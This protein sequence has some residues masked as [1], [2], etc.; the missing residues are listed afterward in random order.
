MDRFAEALLKAA[1]LSPNSKVRP[2]E[3]VMVVIPCALA[4]SYSLFFFF[5]LISAL[6]LARAIGQAAPKLLYLPTKTLVT[7]A[8]L[9]GGLC[10]ACL[11]ALGFAVRA[12][13][14]FLTLGS[15]MLNCFI[16]LANR[17][18]VRLKLKIRELA[19]GLAASLGIITP[20]E[21][22]GSFLAKVAKR[23]RRRVWPFYTDEFGQSYFR[24]TTVGRTLAL[25][26]TCVLGFTSLLREV[27]G[28][29]FFLFFTMLVFLLPIDIFSRANV[30]YSS[31]AAYVAVRV[32]IKIKPKALRLARRF[33]RFKAR[34][35]RYPSMVWFRRYVENKVAEIRRERLR[36]ALRVVFLHPLYF[37]W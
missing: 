25:L 24:R 28:A 17:H 5:A 31:L 8:P 22:E 30:F 20:Q 33:R 21:A 3:V 6:N 35:K 4:A 14:S 37:L 32:F 2:L 19:L 11:N 1:P 34:V 12:L 36:A 26:K 7:L 10:A 15:L 16:I 27:L 18:V 23:V 9:L 13:V 29:L